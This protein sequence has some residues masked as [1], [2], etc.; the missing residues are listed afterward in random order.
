MN[1]SIDNFSK[2]NKESFCRA[3]VSVCVN[4]I[5]IKG[6]R[7]LNGEEGLFVSFPR[8]LGK[9]NKWYSTVYCDSKKDE[10][11]LKDYILSEYK[12]FEEKEKAK[13]V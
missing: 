6:F 13:N 7:V 5:H 3:F 9:D 2:L 11:F 4:E 8:E 10:L 12:K 1:I